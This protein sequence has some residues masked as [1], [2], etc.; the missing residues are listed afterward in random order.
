MSRNISFTSASH[1]C[2]Q[3]VSSLETWNLERSISRNITPYTH[4]ILLN[5]LVL[6]IYCMFKWICYETCYDSQCVIEYILTNNLETLLFI[7]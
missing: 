3:L 2:P 5:L 6:I 4:Y 7:N 1:Q